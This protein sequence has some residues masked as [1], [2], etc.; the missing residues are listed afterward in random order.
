MSTI[1][2]SLSITLIPLNK[3]FTTVYDSLNMRSSK[4]LMILTFM[5]VM[6]CPSCDLLQH[7]VQ[8]MLYHVMTRNHD[9]HRQM[10]E[11]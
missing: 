2:Y 9:K 10:M 4:A 8:Q 1:F 6:L 11:I 5:I 3:R 7:K